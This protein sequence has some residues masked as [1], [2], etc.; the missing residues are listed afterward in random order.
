MTGTPFPWVYEGAGV[1]RTAS[2][3]FANR[4]DKEFTK[5]MQ[6]LLV[7][8]LNIQEGPRSVPEWIG[9]T[10]DEDPPPR[11]KLRTRDK[12]R[13]AD[14][15]LYCQGCTRPISEGEPADVDHIVAIVN[16]G[17]NRENN[18][19]FICFKPCH[20]A[21]TKRDIK[22]KKVTARKRKKLLLTKKRSR[23][24]RWR[25]FKGELVRNPKFRKRRR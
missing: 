22:A 4:A 3:F 10:P 17:Q 14:G 21:K 13:G 2:A 18:L 6:Y 1:M 11:V 5:G 9:R 24:P 25:N 19:R 12:A 7:A 8:F 20:A 15:R 23:F 16:G